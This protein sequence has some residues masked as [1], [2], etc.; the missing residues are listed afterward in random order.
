MISY[1]LKTSLCLLALLLFYKL[2]LEREKMHQF[3][4]FFL[5]GS[6][7]FS[8]IAPL[9]II[10]VAANPVVEEAPIFILSGTPNADQIESTST[11]YINY[12]AILWLC[13]TLISLLLLFRFL[14]NIWSISTKIRK[15]QSVSYKGA[16]LI[17]LDKDISPYT[18][19]NYIFVSKKEYHAN[20]IENELWTHELT[21]VT[22]K[23]TIDIL[24]LEI[25]HILFW[26]NPTYV[27]LK[28]AI[29]LNHEFL[30]DEAVLHTHRNT[31]KYQHLL[32]KRS[33]TENE[34]YL[35]SNLNYILTKKRLL[36]M[37]KQKS[38]NN[39][40]LKKISILPFIGALAFLFAERVEAQEHQPN[41]DKGNVI[42]HKPSKDGTTKVTFKDTNGK[43]VTKNIEELTSEELKMLPLA[44]PPPPPPPKPETGFHSVNNQTL[45]YVTNEKGTKYYN[46]FGQH[47]DK[48]GKI[49][50]PERTKSNAVI[51][52]QNITKVYKD[53]K[54]IT[55]FVDSGTRIG[56]VVRKGD[57]TNIPP[58]PPPKARKK[59]TPPKQEKRQKLGFRFEARKKGQSKRTIDQINKL[60][61]EQ[62]LSLPKGDS[63]NAFIQ[64][65][66]ND[67][68]VSKTKFYEMKPT[69]IA[70]LHI[71]KKDN[72]TKAIYAETR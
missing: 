66:I 57:I 13:Y 26:V 72:G 28:K 36:M 16:K 7:L 62:I 44:P 55:E 12:T 70:T 50:N 64:H 3:N 58:P 48:N 6:I 38:G 2:V 65:Y 9:F 69:E 46:R 5:L 27:F 41:Y 60:S 17:L 8:F 23:H 52:S 43:K 67:K 34:Y 47:V 49:L 32:L 35:A 33:S 63:K 25:L 15:N 22:Q 31:T 14:R 4:R 40:L 11:T 53:N 71:V 54:V 51:P 10:E 1:I 20:S 19:L 24:I 39:I 37:V 59:R 45:F 21:H 68:L 42:V 18:F 30:A 61:N 56:P 29:K